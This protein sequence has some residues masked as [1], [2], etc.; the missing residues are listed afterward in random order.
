MP[1][2]PQ[3]VGHDAERGE[4]MNSHSTPAT[5]GATAYGR[6]GASCRPSRRVMT[7]SANTASTS[8]IADAADG[9]TS[10][11]NKAVVLNDVEVGSF[12][13]QVAEVLH[14]RPIRCE[15]PKASCCWNDCSSACAGRPEEEHDD[16]RHLRREQRP[17]QP[18]D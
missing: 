7:R 18:A 6:S 13:E 5:A 14:A 10:N 12:G 2:A 4:N 1:S 3:R 11:E 15:M 17:G 16:D 8:D 9:A